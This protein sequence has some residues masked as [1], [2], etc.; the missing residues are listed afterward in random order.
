M[1]PSAK[2]SS[3]G[4]GFL[5]SLRI[6]TFALLLVIRQSSVVVHLGNERQRSGAATATSEFSSALPVPSL[7]S[8]RG[9][10]V[11][12]KEANSNPRL[13]TTPGTVKLRESPFRAGD[14][15]I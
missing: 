15:T 10:G 11:R 8:G 2:I 5:F 3:A 12:G 9:V 7:S 1:W 14:F 6:G 13:T 4:V